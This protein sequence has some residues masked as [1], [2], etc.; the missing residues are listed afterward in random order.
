DGMAAVMSQVQAREGIVAI[1]GKYADLVEA[2]EPVAR[3]R[4]MRVHP[5]GDFYPSGDEFVTVYECTKRVVPPG[6]LPLD[7]GC[8]VG[9]VETMLNVQR[10]EPVT[11]KY[12]T[13]AGDVPEPMSV[14]VPV[15]TTYRDT[16]T[17]AG[18][19]VDAIG[20]VL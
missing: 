8:L 1:K 19:D 15:G 2:L 9:N 3:T 14:R 20:S 16:L 4:G 7:V 10:R 5:L 17:A 18:V 13:I 11:H 6:G 12:L